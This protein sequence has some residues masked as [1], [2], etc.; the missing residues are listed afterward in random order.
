MNNVIKDGTHR[1]YFE[2]ESGFITFICN[3]ALLINDSYIDVPSDDVSDF[4]SGSKNFLDYKIV[5]AAEVMAPVFLK[6][7][8]SV[9]SVLLSEV[10][11]LETESE[12]I[13]VKNYPRLKKWKFKLSHATKSTLKTLKLNS[14]LQVYVVDALNPNFLY[15]SIL[16]DL[17]ELLKNDSVIVDHASV[18]E[19]KTSK[20]KL[21]TNKLFT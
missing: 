21:F 13:T 20:V 5:F 14:S 18:I 6:K 17:E 15:R 7:Y 4:L 9:D 12:M 3:E 2:K 11:E 10:P 1:V 16:L 19:Q 8:E